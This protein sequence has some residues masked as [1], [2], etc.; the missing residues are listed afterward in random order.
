MWDLRRKET[1][2]L[3]FR[4]RW[5]VGWHARGSVYHTRHFNLHT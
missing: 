5:S 1:M 2:A 3:G 4:E